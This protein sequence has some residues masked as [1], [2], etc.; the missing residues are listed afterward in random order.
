MSIGRHAGWFGF[1]RLLSSVPMAIACGF[2][3]TKPSFKPQFK[4][5]WFGAIT[6]LLLTLTYEWYFL[7]RPSTPTQKNT[8]Q[9]T[10]L[11]P[12]NEHLDCGAQALEVSKGHTTNSLSVLEISEC[13]FKPPIY[14]LP[15]GHLTVQNNT[16]RSV[17]IHLLVFEREKKRTLW[18]VVLQPKEQ[19]NFNAIIISSDSIGM[20]YSDSAPEFRLSAVRNTSSNHAWSLSRKPIKA[21]EISEKK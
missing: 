21:I 17:N 19:R 2:A 9:E 6:L 7:N 5:T 16:P 12:S 4:F 11:I 14:T 10:R 3:M 20:L 8:I 15:N 13:G 1:S 18:N